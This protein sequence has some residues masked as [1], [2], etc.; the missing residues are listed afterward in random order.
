MLHRLRFSSNSKT[1]RPTEDAALHGDL[2]HELWA[3]VSELDKVHRTTIILRIANDLSIHEI[4]E[5]MDVHEKT[6]YSRLYAAVRE[7]RGTLQRAG[8]FD[9]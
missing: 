7:L 4:S 3:A 2:T 6:V 5:I 9:P 1:K 8:Y